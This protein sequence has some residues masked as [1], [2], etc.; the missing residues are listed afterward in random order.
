MRP[1]AEI[2]RY[3]VVMYGSSADKPDLKAKVELYATPKGHPASAVATATMSVGK[4]K[5]HDGPLPPDTQEKE[6]IVMHLPHAMLGQVMDLLR[7]EAPVY[8]AF[9]EGRAVLG[10]GVEEIGSGDEQHPRLVRVVDGPPAAAQVVAPP[11]A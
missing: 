10:T 6:Q 1:M 7:N 9:H 8:F 2:N 3:R 5:F 11:T 4:I